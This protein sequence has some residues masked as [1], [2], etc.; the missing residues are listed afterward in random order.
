MVEVEW[1]LSPSYKKR[2]PT[3]IPNPATWKSGFPAPLMKNPE[4]SNWNPES[5][6]H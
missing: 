2:L 5:K 6:N 3:R 4:S 1:E